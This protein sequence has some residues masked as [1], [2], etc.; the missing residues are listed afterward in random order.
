MEGETFRVQMLS[1][2]EQ[3]EVSTAGSSLSD[4][5]RGNQGGEELVSFE[6]Q[7]RLR[8]LFSALSANGFFEKPIL[9]HALYWVARE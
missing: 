1:S 3:W 9:S 4:E 7:A 8:T 2:G 5:V 6:Y